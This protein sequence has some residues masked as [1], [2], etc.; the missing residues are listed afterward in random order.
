LKEEETLHRATTLKP[1]D[2]QLPRPDSVGTSVTQVVSRARKHYGKQPTFQSSTDWSCGPS[3][4]LFELP[5]SSSK[6]INDVVRGD[7]ATI[8]CCQLEA[9][10]NCCCCCDASCCPPVK[11]TWIRTINV[12]SMNFRHS[13]SAMQQIHEAQKVVSEA[14]R[15]DLTGQLC[16]PSRYMTV[17]IHNSEDSTVMATDG[18]WGPTEVVKET[19]RKECSDTLHPLTSGSTRGAHQRAV[20]AIVSQLADALPQNPF[21]SQLG[22]SG[23]YCHRSVSPQNGQFS[24][25]YS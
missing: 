5:E 24:H 13:N 8:A 1:A 4:Q 14:I 6:P 10:T 18:V 2:F 3:T 15:A 21:I 25:A 20:K 9:E 22:S 16:C 12:K 7:T 11:H 19:E 17:N 23:A